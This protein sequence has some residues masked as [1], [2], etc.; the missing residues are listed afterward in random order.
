MSITFA[1]LG[2]SIAVFLTVRNA[3]GGQVLHPVFLFSGVH[4]LYVFP[5]VLALSVSNTLA[6]EYFRTNGVDVIVAYMALLCYLATLL[7]YE[8]IAPKQSVTYSIG[9]LKTFTKRM[10]RFAVIVGGLGLLGFFGLFIMNGGLH[11]YYFELTFYQMELRGP[12]VWLIFL[13]RFIFPA[14]AA[15]ALVV[16]LNPSSLSL[17]FLA[18]LSAFPLMNVLFL[19]RRE[20]IF[21]L[22]FIA[23]Y[24]LIVSGRAR[25]NRLFVLPSIGVLALSISLFPYLRQDSI[26]AA[27]S[28]DY[29]TTDMTVQERIADA[30]EVNADDEIVRAASTIEHTYRTGDYQF[31]AF[32]WN[33]LVKQFMPATLLGAEAK[34]ALLLGHGTESDSGQDYFDQEA[35]FY[36]AP[37]GFSQAYEQFG[38]FGW[39][40]FAAIGAFIALIERK[41]SKLSNRVFLM[42]ALPIICLAATNDI[43]STPA[44]LVTFWALTRFL[45]KARLRIYPSSTRS[46]PLRQTVQEG[47]TASR[48][49]EPIVCR[50]FSYQIA[51]KRL[52]R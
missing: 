32:I 20:D 45:G 19:F 47:G 21:F 48:F 27:T 2:L 22:G 7:A 4:A 26:S 17:S 29:R 11:D 25:L 6:A 46:E 41:S 23:I 35:F 33:S 3:H 44:R 52:L 36:V 43:T 42:V 16:V 49:R 31:G 40:I 18:L 13:S 9:D 39:I 8:F 30:F 10:S 1:L 28:W 24:A 15:M 14:I 51:V 5:K 38:P 34:S 50:K 37:M 12:T